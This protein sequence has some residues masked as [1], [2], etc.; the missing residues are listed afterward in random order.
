M[1]FDKFV[2]I[3]RLYL[4]SDEAAAL[5]SG[6]TCVHHPVYLSKGSEQLILS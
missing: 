4:E 5:P 2:R 6:M 3:S 1:F